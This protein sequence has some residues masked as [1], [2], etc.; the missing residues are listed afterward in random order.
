[1][2]RLEIDTRPG[3]GN[4]IVLVVLVVTALVITTVWYREG[5]DGPL[6]ATRRVVLAAS[7][8]F[9]LAGSFVTS[10]VRALTG[11]ITDTAVSRE[12]A[13]ALRAQN[14]QLKARVAELEEAKLENERIRELVKFAQAQDFQTVGARV[15]GRP[16]ASWD[17][18]IVIDKGSDADVTVEAPVIAAGGLVGQ[19]VEVTAI[20]A[21]VRLITDADSGVAVIIQR[22]RGEGVVRGSVDGALSL[23][24]VGKDNVPVKGDVLLTSGMGGAYPKGLVVGEVS[25]VA[26]PQADLYPKVGVQSRVPIDRIEEVLVLA[27]SAASQSGAGE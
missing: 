10:P 1:M 6:H 9:A 15:I 5:P 11:F 27:V 8:P 16:V 23:Q 25:T 4:P 24:Y 17:H 21:K 2:K 20:D 26:A 3:A 14:E 12:E 19:V 18:S 7:K 22:T 13:I